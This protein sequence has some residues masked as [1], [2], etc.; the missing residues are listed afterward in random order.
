LVHRVQVWVSVLDAVH[1]SGHAGDN[2]ALLQ[3]FPF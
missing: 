2:E 3:D 1:V